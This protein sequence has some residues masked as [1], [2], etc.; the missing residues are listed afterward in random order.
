[1]QHKAIG[2]L[3]AAFYYQ[4]KKMG[5]L[6]PQEFGV[7]VPDPAVSLACSAYFFVSLLNLTRAAGLFSSNV[8]LRN[9]D[10]AST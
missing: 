5:V 1:V 2:A 10:Q 7:S 9:G 3:I 4:K 8:V 6:F